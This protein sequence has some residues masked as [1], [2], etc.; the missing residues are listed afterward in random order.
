MESDRRFQIRENV[1]VPIL[2][3]K[4]HDESY[5]LAMI[6]NV[7]MNGMF[8]ESNQRFLKGECFFIKINKSLPG[9]ES[10]TPYDAC[11]AKVKWCEKTDI[12]SN[13][14]VGV[15]QVGK[16]K[17]VK[18]KPVDPSIPCCEL[19]GNTS[20]PEI[21]KTDEHVCLCLNCFTRVSQLSGKA[22][23]DNINRFMVGNVI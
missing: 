5:H 12:D 1:N 7:S 13:Y 17:V 8:F 22:F 2:Y 15:K 9:F 19:C 18:K 6:H 20:M 3:A 14:K 11:A 10:V 16:A 4:D 23:K 21:V